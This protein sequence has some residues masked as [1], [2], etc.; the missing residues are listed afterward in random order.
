MARAGGVQQFQVFGR[1]QPDQVVQGLD[2]FAEDG[3]PG[4]QQETRRPAQVLRQVSRAVAELDRVVFQQAGQLPPQA[5]M[6]ER[7]QRAAR[8]HA[9]V[10]HRRFHARVLLVDQGDRRAAAQQL[11]RAADAHNARAQDDDVLS[12]EVLLE[13]SRPGIVLQRM[14]AQAGI[15]RV[16]SVRLA[17]AVGPGY[18]QPPRRPT[19]RLL[20]RRNNPTSPHARTG[21]ARRRPAAR[22][23][24]GWTGSRT[25]GRPSRGRAR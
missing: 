25:A 6:V 23:V 24:P 2:G 13:A 17:A 8:Q 11:Q 4:V 20:R 1:G 12:H 16:G 19:T 15:R 5:R 14:P 9:G 10:A 18:V 7:H 22:P 3:R 21:S